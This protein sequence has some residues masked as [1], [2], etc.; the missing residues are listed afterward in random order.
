MFKDDMLPLIENQKKTSSLY[1]LLNF[2]ESRKV[3]SSLFIF[4][5]LE[6]KKEQCLIMLLIRGFYEPK[7]VHAHLV[8]S[9]LESLKT[10]KKTLGVSFFVQFSLLRPK[11]YKTYHRRT[12][13]SRRKGE[14]FSH[15]VREVQKRLN[16]HLPNT[17]SKA[18]YIA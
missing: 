10:L 2:N 9:C 5:K 11:K 7:L 17:P 15:L 4:D 8:F 16:Y 12:L 6:E 14:P 13:L 18:A 1:F 3:N